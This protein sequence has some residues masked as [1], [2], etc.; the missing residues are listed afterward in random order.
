[1]ASRSVLMA[2]GTIA[3]SRRITILTGRRSDRP[4]RID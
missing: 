1:M 4:V 2:I 3:D